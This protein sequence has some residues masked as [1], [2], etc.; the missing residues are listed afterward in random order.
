[1]LALVKHFDGAIGG[2]RSYAVRTQGS[3]I[4]I[5]APGADGGNEV[6]LGKYQGTCYYR[7]PLQSPE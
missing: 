1:M 6:R 7:T 2:H 4:G 3:P 5:G